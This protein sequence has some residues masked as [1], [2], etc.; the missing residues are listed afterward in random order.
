MSTSG[1]IESVKMRGM[2]ILVLVAC[3]VNLPRTYP[4]AKCPTANVFD[5]LLSQS[6]LVDEINKFIILSMC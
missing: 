5:F 3:V 6:K 1:I 4:R 2:F